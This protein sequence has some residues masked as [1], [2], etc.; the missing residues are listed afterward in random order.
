M[1]LSVNARDAMPEG[2]RLTIETANVVLDKAY[3]AQHIAAEPG[4]YVLLSIT[5]TGVGMSDQVKAHLFEPFFTTK[6]QGKGTGLGL[7]TVYGIVKQG[8]GQIGVYSEV[9]LGTTFR[10][11]LPSAAMPR[12]RMGRADLEGA[13]GS[14][15]AEPVGVQQGIETILVVEDRNDL[16]LLAE[17]VLGMSGYQVMAAADGSQALKLSQEYKSPIHLL[18]TDLVMPDMSGT[19][20]AEQLRLQ[21]PEMQ[22]LYMSGY[23]DRP[24][25]KQIVAEQGAAFLSK[26][27]T[28]EELTQKVRDVL[29]S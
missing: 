3:A 11:Y 26:P 17:Q 2:G 5:D 6:E 1:N 7:A 20:L 23:A 15:A 29:E 25:V 22:V 27:F 10:I 21:R 12:A 28:V 18:L 24:L 9:G 4:D 16:R 13:E 19:K 8:G 14:Q